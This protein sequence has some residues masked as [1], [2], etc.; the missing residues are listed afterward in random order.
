L[1]TTQRMVI[2]RPTPRFERFERV[3]I[4][5]DAIHFKEFRGAQGTILWRDFLRGNPTRPDRWVYIVQLSGSDAYKAILE[6]DLQSEGAFDPEAV[7]FGKRAEISFD[8]VTE[9]DMAFIEGSYRRPGRFWQVAILAKD[10][11][12]NLQYRPSTWESGMTGVVF[13]APRSVKLNREYAFWAMTR[14]FG[15]RDWVEVNGPDSM[16][17]R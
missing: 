2:N 6:S 16:V 14:A 12:P 3:V 9:P 15:H 7:H 5:A 4:A 1:K 13:R 8:V 11:V 10:D 17:L